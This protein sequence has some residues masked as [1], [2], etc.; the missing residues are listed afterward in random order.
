MDDK[1]QGKAASIQALKARAKR[2]LPRYIY[3]YVAGGC[4]SDSAVRANRD[5]LESL[6]LQPRYLGTAA[7]LDTT[8]E[9][10]GRSYSLPLGIAP[11]GLS[12]LI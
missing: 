4:I 11:I 3:E 1:L 2:R 6:R 9:F 8:T 10:L 12:G 7:Q 5:A